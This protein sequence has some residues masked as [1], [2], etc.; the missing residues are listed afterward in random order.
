MEKGDTFKYRANDLRKLLITY[1]GYHVFD[2]ERRA[3]ISFGID[4][5]KANVNF[6]HKFIIRI[7]S[8]EDAISELQFS[9]NQS[10]NCVYDLILNNQWE[11]LNSANNQQINEIEII[12]D[13]SENDLFAIRLDNTRDGLKYGLSPQCLISQ[14][15]IT[16]KVILNTLFMKNFPV[17]RV[18]LVVK[19]HMPEDIIWNE[20][21]ILIDLALIEQIEH[22]LEINTDL[23][24]FDDPNEQASLMDKDYHIRLTAKGRERFERL[25]TGYGNT[26][27]I[28][29]WCELKW[30]ADFFR[31]AVKEAGYEEYIQEYEEPPK[32]IGSDIKERIANSTFIIADLTGG[33]ENCLYELGYAHA[34]HKRTIITREEEEVKKITK[35][36]EEVLKLT[37][38]INQ[39]KHSFWKDENDENFKNAIRERIQQTIKAIEQDYFAI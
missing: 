5:I 28:I 6:I 29:I 17:P 10:I 34:L 11:V 7:S 25:Y 15:R 4:D 16:Q 13:F 21:N 23:F 14:S 37:F 38:D 3:R 39:Y 9:I 22:E 18:W 30:L 8:S 12:H 31:E 26:V 32:D 20:I 27:F 36:D 35:A 1:H 33:R 24:T 2:Y 19:S